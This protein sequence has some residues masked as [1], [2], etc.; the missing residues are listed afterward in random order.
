MQLFIKGLQGG[1][2]SVLSLQESDTVADLKAA[3][4]DSHGIPASEQLL[5]ANGR[6]LSNAASTLATA[7]LQDSSSVTLLLRLC[8]GKGGFGALLRGQGRDGKITDNFDAMRDLSG[9]RI[10]HVEAEKRL[11]E[12]KQDAKE[13]ELEVIAMRHMKEMAKQAKADR[14]FQVNVE[15]VKREHKKAA[16]AVVEAV[17][18]ALSE[19]LQHAKNGGSRP[20]NGTA[21]KPAAGTAAAAAEEQ[22][23]SPGSKRKTAEGAA[24]ANGTAGAAA[25]TTAAKKRKT[26]LDMVQGADSDEDDSSSDDASDEEA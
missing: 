2:S 19:G 25:A 7:G 1:W 16:D 18:T 14:D 17:H 6:L 22:A 11:Q 21:A 13:R 23:V 20:V 3:V 10:K 4:E 12:W 9:R 5:T 15:E 24:A 8:G 26:M